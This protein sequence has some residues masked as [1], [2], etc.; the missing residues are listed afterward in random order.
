MEC[1]GEPREIFFFLLGGKTLAYR[2]GRINQSLHHISTVVVMSCIP[3]RPRVE[4]SCCT[5]SR[6]ISPGFLHNLW[7]LLPCPHTPPL[8]NDRLILQTGLA[9]LHS[10]SQEQSSRVSTPVVKRSNSKGLGSPPQK[11]WLRLVNFDFQL[12]A[13]LCLGF[14]T[15]PSAQKAIPCGNPN[16]EVGSF[17]PNFM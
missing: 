4:I 10:G 8:E 15:S 16:Y 3:F 12:V 6:I 9:Q 14:R 2:S 13:E 17:H 5:A 11:S 1:P 7:S